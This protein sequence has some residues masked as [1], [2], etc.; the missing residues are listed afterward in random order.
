MFVVHLRDAWRGFPRWVG[1][2]AALLEV[3]LSVFEQLVSWQ[4]ASASTPLFPR[5]KGRGFSEA[6]LAVRAS[7]LAAFPSLTHGVSLALGARCPS[8]P[9]RLVRHP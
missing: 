5:G 9:S 3:Y 1:L 4:G 2:L 6:G 8:L 7:L